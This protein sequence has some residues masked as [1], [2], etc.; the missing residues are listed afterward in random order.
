MTVKEKL[1]EIFQSY[2]KADLQDILDFFKIDYSRTMRKGELYDLLIEII[3]EEPEFWLGS[4]PERDIKLLEFLISK[5]ADKTA[6][7]E[8]PDYPS[9]LE[10]LR[11]IDSDNSDP[12]FLK[13]SISPE[14]SSLVEPHLKKVH[15]MNEENSTY[16]LERLI[17]GCLNIYGIIP[18]DELVDEIVEKLH[19]NE[20]EDVDECVK[21]VSRNSLMKIYGEIIDGRAY[22]FSPSAYDYQNILEERESF[23]E[24]KDF[25]S[26]SIE[27]ILEAGGDAPYSC[28]GIN[29]PEGE[30]LHS[31]LH[32][33][34]YRGDD[35]K[36]IIHDIWIYS[37]FTIDDKSTENLFA[38]VTAKQ[39]L[40]RDF[41]NYK[42]CIDT[43]V[44]YA[45]ILPKWLLKGHSANEMDL[46]K[47]SI[48]VDDG[49]LHSDSLPDEIKVNLHYDLSS[50]CNNIE[51][52]ALSWMIFVAPDKA[53][54]QKNR[55]TLS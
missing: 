49:Y 44:E 23:P 11:L 29:T 13:L 8:Y 51:K 16:M 1:G 33:L 17:L 19:L 55:R 21:F 22:F 45:N 31:M 53:A 20:I 10:T 12:N 26:F 52:A 7:I 48:K 36:R 18:A 28:F 24:A 32:G 46:M 3:A 34:G 47:I 2:H 4:L 6:Y 50:L 37:Q 35:L 25:K 40:I 15:A 43:I 9:L 54:S 42:E 38:S 14:I 39:E 27:E 30:K 41:D 5:G